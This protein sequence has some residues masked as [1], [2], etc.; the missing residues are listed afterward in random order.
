MPR[1]PAP[2]PELVAERKRR[3]S[4]KAN[5]PTLN[6][7]L[8]IGLQVA[9]DFVG[10]TKYLIKL[11]QTKPAL[12]VQL[13]GKYAGKEGAEAETDIRFIVQQFTINATPI[14]GVSNSPIQGHVSAPRLAA[15]NGEV[16]DAEVKSD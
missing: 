4:G 13:L 9:L 8:E 1:K 10:G 3:Q 6:R 2:P 5:R 12:F 7:E 15:S 11:A 16:I 14:P